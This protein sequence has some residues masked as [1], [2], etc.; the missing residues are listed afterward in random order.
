MAQWTEC[1]PV[2]RRV[3]FDSHS[4]HTPGLWARPPGGGVREAI[5]SLTHERF[6]P[7]LSPSFLLSL[8]NKWKLERRRMYVWCSFKKIFILKKKRTENRNEDINLEGG[9]HRREGWRSKWVKGIK[10]RRLSVLAFRGMQTKMPETSHEHICATGEGPQSVKSCHTRTHLYTLV[11]THAH[12]HTRAHGDLGHEPW[13]TVSECSSKHLDYNAREGKV[14]HTE[15]GR[16]Y[17]AKAVSR[18]PPSHRGS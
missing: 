16:L 6:S 8:K 17:V 12:A 18:D 14:A 3:A 5:V 11:Q 15:D 4:G 10:V 9:E 13:T 2:N 1:W 7:S